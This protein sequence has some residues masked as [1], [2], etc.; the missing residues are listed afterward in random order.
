MARIGRGYENQGV[1]LQ[2]STGLVSI[3]RTGDPA[4]GAPGS[5]GRFG[6]FGLILNNAG[7]I[8]FEATFNGPEPGDG[9]FEYSNGN[10]SSAV[11]RGQSA[12]GTQGGIFD[13]F[14]GLAINQAGQIAFV[15]S[16][17]GGPAASGVFVADNAG[18]RMLA[19]EG[20]PA[21]YTGGG[22]FGN[23]R[24]PSINDSGDVAFVD[25]TAVRGRFGNTFF[26]KGLFVATSSTI[27][28]VARVRD[29]V[30]PGD[31]ILTGNFQQPTIVRNAGKNSV[32]FVA[33]NQVQG[34]NSLLFYSNNSLVQLLQEGDPAV[35]GGV[36]SFIG[37]QALA[38]SGHLAFVSNLEGAS[39]KAGIF[40]NKLSF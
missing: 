2:T 31:P 12:P 14:L 38:S 19:L 30:R 4:P 29:Q 25:T 16:L 40:V 11:L 17:M 1:F 13:H 5:F 22:T 35:V 6:Q 18:I 27:S 7:K 37:N 8:A 28:A 36:H 3:A 24:Q 10:L 9:I 34:R 33:W 15:A 39:A 21:P 20:Q 23:L 26:P 32:L